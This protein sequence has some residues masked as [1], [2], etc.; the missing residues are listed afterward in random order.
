[1][2][3]FDG[4]DSLRLDLRSK[5]RT[6]C[7]TLQLSQGGELW[8]E[9]WTNDKSAL[10]RAKIGNPYPTGWVNWVVATPDT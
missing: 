8:L 7:L 4:T 10:S 6:Y 5:R 3:T 1:M 2:L 9:D